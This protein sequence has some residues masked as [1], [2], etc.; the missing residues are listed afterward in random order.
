MALGFRP[1]ALAHPTRGWV[2]RIF[3][4]P[5]LDDIFRLSTLIPTPLQWLWRPR[6]PAG[7][8]SILVGHPDRG[9]TIIACT[10]SGHVSRGRAWP[11]G[12]SCPQGTVLFL[13][14]EDALEETIVPRLQ[15]ADADLTHILTWKARDLSRLSTLLESVHP[16]LCILSPLNTYLP[17]VNT[18]NDQDVR[19]VLQPLADL[20]LKS[21]ATFLGIMHPPKSKQS[22]PIHTIVGS[23]AFGAVARSV[24]AVE[25]GEHGLYLMEGIKQNL[26]QAVPPIGYRLI[27]WSENPDVA[28]LQWVEVSDTLSLI[29]ADD[30]Q[31]ALAEACEY[32]RMALAGGAVTSNALKLGADKNGIAWRTIMRARKVLGVHA[33]R[34]YLREKSCWQLSLPDPSK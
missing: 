7:R 23:V 5:M 34:V 28:Q 12:Q 27:P 31:S 10:F 30:D 1:V 24:L 13:E 32:L 19:R 11:D 2:A 22:L 18:W 6:L 16:K 29:P 20:A 17:R 9:K 21:G 25:R 26:A 15:A 8:L 4:I 3:L 14:A 33:Q